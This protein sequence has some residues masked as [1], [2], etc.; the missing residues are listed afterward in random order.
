VSTLAIA[1]LPLATLAGR[2]HRPI[3]LGR[4]VLMDATTTE[5][6]RGSEDVR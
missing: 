5:E 4:V 1:A 6:H 2:A 3:R